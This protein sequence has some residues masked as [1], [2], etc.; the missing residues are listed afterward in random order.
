MTDPL[1]SRWLETHLFTPSELED[2]RL[3]PYR[4]YAGTYLKLEEERIWEVEIT[5]IETGRL[6]HRVLERFLKQSPSGDTET[7][8]RRALQ[9]LDEEISLFSETR[10]NLSKVLLEISEKKIERTLASFVEDHLENRRQARTLQPLHFEWAFGTKT[11][12]LVIKGEIR[13]RGRIDRIDVDH[14]AKRFLVIDY[15]T[16]STKITGNQILKGESL[17]LPLYVLAVQRLL[18]PDYEPIGGLYYQLSDM[19][20]KDGILHADRLPPFLE[21]HPRSSSLIPAIK[22]D[23]TLEGI[24]ET[25]RSI[26]SEIRKGEFPSRPDPC[27]PYCPYRDICRIRSGQ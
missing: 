1:F 5:P 18:L 14:K 17:Q 23:A 11:P 22:W 6:I 21:I 20:M 3:C 25:V 16:G 10:P 7:L 19:T 8:K 26:V 24:E 9:I 27:E 13:I 15:K 12:P 2:Y 4:F